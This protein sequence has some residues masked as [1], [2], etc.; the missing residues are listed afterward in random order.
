MPLNKIILGLW[1]LNSALII[2]IIIKIQYVE[3]NYSHLK[4][5]HLNKYT[6][7]HFWELST[8]R[9]V[10]CNY[11]IAWYLWD[12]PPMLPWDTVHG[13]VSGIVSTTPQTDHRR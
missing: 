6:V 7:T 4:R 13:N 1:H 12:G 5:C 9:P 3:Q 8:E 2:V 11:G 10:Y